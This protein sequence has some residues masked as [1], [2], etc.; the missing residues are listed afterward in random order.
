MTKTCEQFKAAM[1]KEMKRAEKH[2]EDLYMEAAERHSN[3]RSGMSKVKFGKR[4][5]LK[6]KRGTGL[7]KVIETEKEAQAAGGIMVAFQRA[8]VMVENMKC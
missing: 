4:G 3:A 5:Q 6:V 8:R 7:G 1:L 2:A